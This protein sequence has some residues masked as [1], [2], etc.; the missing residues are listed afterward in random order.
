M[1]APLRMSPVCDARKATSLQWNVRENMRVEEQVDAADSMRAATLGIADVSYLARTGFKGKGVA[2][3]LQAQ[4]IPVPAQPN[5]WAPLAGGGVVLRL[6]VSEYLIE[7]GLTHGSSARMAH[8]DTPVHVYPVLHQDVALVLC[9]E[10]VHELLLQ[11]CNVNF[12]A[13]D[14][15]FRP[16]VLTS[17]A[18]VAVTVMPGARAGRAYYRVW[19]DGTY[20]LYLWETLSGIAAELGGGPVGLAAITDIDQLAV[21]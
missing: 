16:V 9:G 6:G 21:R 7:D 1:N 15:A 14:L 20:G 8:L 3:W 5:S 10:A 2:A 13:L 4:D 11:T 18:G 19:A 12:G 17:M